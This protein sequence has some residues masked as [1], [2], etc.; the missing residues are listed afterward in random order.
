MKFQ[1]R[2]NDIILLASLLLVNALAL[3]PMLDT[4]FISDDII[5]SQIRGHMIET[6]RSLWGVT[7]FYAQEW[8]KNEGRLFPF[9]FYIYSV[10]YVLQNILLYKLFVLSAVLASIAAFFFFVRRLT[11]SELIPSIALLLLPVMFQF[12]GSWDPILA[13]CAQ[14]PVVCLFLYCSLNLFLRALDEPERGVPLLAILLFLC[15]GL[16]FEVVYPMC[17]LYVGVAYVRLD[18]LKPSF[19]VSLPFITV[20]LCLVF[21][22]IIFRKLAIAPSATYQMHIDVGL[23]L[24]TYLLQVC[25]ALPFVYYIF[26]PHAIF[27]DQRDKWPV[28]LVQIFPLFILLS[29]LT[30]V[31]IGRRLLGRY[32]RLD[33]VPRSGL[34]AIGIMLFILPAALIS[35]SPKY[36]MQP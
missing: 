4:G 5:N 8:L 33:T 32:R 24:K 20:T 9:A 27:A 18:K 21:A 34:A 2:R 11:S 25:G 30:V 3:M 16:V 36:Q 7:S 12:R 23:I 19:R 29:A 13:F 22:S 15:S 35:L 28:A 1:T 26:D 10:F 6:N 31:A 17:L 14:Y